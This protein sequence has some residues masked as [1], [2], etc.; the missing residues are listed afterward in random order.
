MILTDKLRSDSLRVVDSLAFPE[1]KTRSVASLVKQF[2]FPKKNILFISEP[3]NSDL[4]LV[5]R[6]LPSVQAIS[7]KSLNAVDLLS[8][9]HVVFSTAAIEYLSSVM[10]TA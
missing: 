9:G 5:S 7:I 8:C 6:N 2:G 1:Q 4:H 10:V 3:T